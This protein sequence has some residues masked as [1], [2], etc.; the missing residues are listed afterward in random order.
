MKKNLLLIV[1]GVLFIFSACEKDELL[2]QEEVQDCNIIEVNN[3]IDEPT[4][5][6]AG[7]VYVIKEINISVRSVLT[8]EP[9]VVVK[10]KG[11][12]ITVVDGVISAKGTA[13]NRIV[14]TS[15]ADDSYCG[16]TNGDGI[17]TAPLKGDWQ[18]I[19]FNGTNG[20][21]FQYVDILYAGTNTGGFYN[22][23]KVSGPASA[24]FTFDNCV[25]AH[26][27]SASASFFNNCAFYGGSAMI[28]PAI[29]VF[30]NNIF[31]DN[32]R[33]IVLNAYYTLN[34]NNRFHNPKDPNQANTSNGIYL[35]TSNSPSGAVV[36]WSIAEVPYVLDE[37][38]NGSNQTVNIG[39]GAIVKFMRSGAGIASSSS[40]II[41]ISPS[42]LLTSYKDDENGGDTNADGNAS[43][44]A[45]GD[46]KGVYDSSQQIYMQGSNIKYAAN[47]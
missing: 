40:R 35:T 15:L 17:A 30:T 9:G 4:T 25:F 8:I 44:P 2:D 7:N 6:T 16:D 27:L 11:A 41:N 18:Q 43:S 34:T 47:K 32:G 38:F 28:D 5:W 21:I 45:V 13:T 10:L 22:A 46:W 20:T 3:D 39:P 24:Q 31:Y 42:A 14:F 26:T 37:W 29:S 23:V 36:T 12:R 1:L 19:N 33:P